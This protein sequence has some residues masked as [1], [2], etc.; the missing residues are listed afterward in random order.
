M[1]LLIFLLLFSLPASLPFFPLTNPASA[2]GNSW[3]ISGNTVY[4]NDSL[5]YASAT[6]HTISGSSDVVFQFQSKVFTGN[7]DFCWGFNQGIMKPTAI[8]LWQNYTHYFYTNFYQQDWGSITIHNV[9][10]Y[11]N[12][13]ITNYSK[14]NV[15][16]GNKNNTYLYLVNYTSGSGIY[17]FTTFTHI[18]ST[19]TLSG[20]YSHWISKLNN[21]TYFDWNPW[22]VTYNHLQFSYQNMTDWYII[23][24][25]PITAGVTYKCKIH[26]EQCHFGLGLVTGKYWFAFK[27]SSETLSQSIFNNHF[28]CLDPWWDS[29]W[30]YCKVCNIGDK[31][32]GIPLKLTVGNNSGGNVSCGG[33]IKQGNYFKDVRFVNTANTTEYYHWME[34]CTTYTQAT[35]WINNSDNASQ[36]LIYY[37][38]S[39]CSN[40][41][42]RSGT[43]TFLVF[44][45]GSD[46]ASWTN[47]VTNDNGELHF[48]WVGGTASTKTVNINRPWV[49]ETRF[50]QETATNH[51]LYFMVGD[52]SGTGY[53]THWDIDSYRD[54]GV[55]TWKAHNNGADTTIYATMA[56]S[57]YY[58]AKEVCVG[59]GNYNHYL[60]GANRNLLGSSLGT[61]FGNL[62]EVDPI[63]GISFASGSP[64]WHINTYV[65]WIFIYKFHSLMPH[66]SGFGSENFTIQLSINTTTNIGAT[67]ATLNGFL[68]YSVTGKAVMQFQYGL[69]TSYGINTVNQTKTSPSHLIENLTSLLPGNLYHIRIRANNSN[70][71]NFY[72]SD[73]VFLT[74]PSTPSSLFLTCIDSTK[75]NLTWIKGSGANNTIIQRKIGRYPTNRIDGTNIYNGT[76]SGCNDLTLTP[77]QIY[78]YRMWSYT[79]WTSLNQWSDLNT[80]SEILIS[81]EAPTIPR[82]ISYKT[83]V[84][85]TWTLGTGSNHSTAVG[86]TTDFSSTKTD[87]TLLANTSRNF[88]NYSISA[89][90]PYYFLSLFGYKYKIDGYGTNLSGN[91][92]NM[93]QVVRGRGWILKNCNYSIG[94][95]IYCMQKNKYFSNIAVNTNP[96]NQYLKL[97]ETYI[98]VTSANPLTF[99]LNNLR[100]TTTNPNLPEFI[101]FN[102]TNTGSSG[103]TVQFQ[104]GNITALKNYFLYVD[105][106]YSGTYIS[107][108]SGWLTFIWSSWTTHHFTLLSSALNFS[109]FVKYENNSYKY[110]NLSKYGPHQLIIQYKTHR[111]VNWIYNGSFYYNDSWIKSS[112]LKRGQV[113]LS[114][115]D[116]PLW[117]EFHWN[118]TN[119]TMGSIKTIEKFYGYQRK[120]NRSTTYAELVHVPTS[121]SYINVTCANMSATTTTNKLSYP[122]FI[123]DNNLMITIYPNTAKE[124]SQINITYSY[125][126]NYP[127]PQCNRIVFSN[128]VG[129]NATFYLLTNKL[130][131]QVSSNFMNN[132]LVRYSFTFDDR[133]GY[134]F[135]KPAFSVYTYVYTYDNK[136]NKLIIDE[137]YW[138]SSQRVYPWLLF[139][140]SYFIGIGSNTYIINNVGLAPNSD[141]STTTPQVTVIGNTSHAY[142]LQDVI[143]VTSGWYFTVHTNSTYSYNSFWVKYIDKSSQTIF[144]ILR[145]YNITSGVLLQT[146]TTN[147]SIANWSYHNPNPYYPSS[148][149]WVITIKHP[150]WTDDQGRYLNQTITSFIY[151]YFPLGHGRYNGSWINYFLNNTIGPTPFK[152]TDKGSPWYGKEVPWVYVIIFFIAIFLA[153]SFDP[154]HI[155]VGVI[156]SGLWLMFASYIFN[157]LATIGTLGA[158]GIAA[159]GLFMIAM[160]ILAE[161]GGFR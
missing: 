102:V 3:T 112:N 116:T 128:S 45:T 149:K 35:F 109:I 41:T 47:T 68:F 13:G 145:I 1:M 144:A 9:T 53:G 152:N 61:T 70:A 157:H 74:K 28:Y 160:G 20:N 146:N 97:N 69:T 36:I 131:Y 136:S 129:N 140:K 64:A 6:P 130:V 63:T 119:S 113:N 99:Q 18:G 8:W 88:D 51:N 122:S 50:R 89:G 56:L 133:S 29:N 90:Q 115:P 98:Y 125:S 48:A 104:L 118:D 15:T 101:S 94:N 4:V 16:L 84:N 17:A 37:G 65:T 91:S 155:N 46:V 24:S 126:N 73:A 25:Q 44:S 76:S 159:V 19:Y 34:N 21:V 72:S 7:V 27:P 127:R 83:S 121:R 2:P 100:N 110:V 22:N 10:S 81:P 143:N 39:I 105:N 107:S 87:G 134:F 141:P 138:D 150:Y 96:A 111:E 82:F 139:G 154:E 5:V 32:L 79:H 95:I 31:I 62:G 52:G 117:F 142:N 75:I 26:L 135:N 66:W 57:T 124:F 77:G 54:S 103:S 132:S 123:W 151:P 14:Y 161:L 158:Y 30:A 33:H 147:S 86:K 85:T 120:Q 55:T 108:A 38:N 92:A 23:Y 12:L 78:L 156:A 80:S 71:L 137:E 148:Y 43:K 58:I 114:A 60:Y 59:A 49:I 40:S 93:T 106:V 42:Y 11:T 153:L 67:T